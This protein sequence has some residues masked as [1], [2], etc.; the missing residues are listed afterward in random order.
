MEK[1]EKAFIEDILEVLYTAGIHEEPIQL[2]DTPMNIA[3]V[4]YPG[5]EEVIASHSSRF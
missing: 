2:E 3:N 1:K 5:K 4:A